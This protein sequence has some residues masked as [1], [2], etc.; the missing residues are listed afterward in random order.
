MKKDP[1]CGWE[2]E[3]KRLRI[4]AISHSADRRLREIRQ[5]AEKCGWATCI[6]RSAT[7]TARHGIAF[8]QQPDKKKIIQISLLAPQGFFS[9]LRCLFFAYRF[10]RLP[11]PPRSLKD[12]P[13]LVAQPFENSQLLLD[14]FAVAR[15]F[16][17][18]L[19]FK[20]QL[21][22]GR[23]FTQLPGFSGGEFAAASV[24]MFDH[25]PHPS[26]ALVSRAQL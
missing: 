10:E 23:S 18:L 11:P 7:L 25:P 24:Q 26:H 4:Q 3:F 22:R 12:F 6:Y 9:I 20:S 21:C 1:R 8:Y 13:L 14:F 17:L 16:C 19:Q 2:K 15:H 5:Q